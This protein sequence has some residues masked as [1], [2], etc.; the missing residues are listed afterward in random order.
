MNESG[1][2]C[3]TLILCGGKG[4]RLGES[5]KSTPKTLMELQGKSILYRKLDHGI[6]QGF[7]DYIIAIGYKGEMVVGACNEMDL[8]FKVDFSDSGEE[9]GML[10]RI[11]DAK[12]LFEERVIV[13]YGDSI[14]NLKWARLIDFHREKNSLLTIIVA[15]IQSPF[16]L[17]T[18]NQDNRVLTLKEKPILNYY[19]GSF[20]M[21]KKAMEF[22]PEQ[23]LNWP[24]GSG[25][26]AFFKILIAIN[27]LFAFVHE[28]NDITFNTIEELNA[29]KKD[30]LKFYTHFQ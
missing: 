3:K 17:V 30:F 4:T 24:D 8:A 14:S 6:K 19:I 29:A 18:S 25:L 9:A 7:S 1:E 23:I 12:D 26:I 11:Y 22:I 20:V 10:R 2:F 5:G 27:K 21:E 28:G 13:T 16:G 15:P